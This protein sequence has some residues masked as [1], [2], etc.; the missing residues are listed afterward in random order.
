MSQANVLMQLWP[1]VRVQRVRP[2]TYRVLLRP[3]DYGSE[4]C[5]LLN[6]SS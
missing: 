1:P 4:V 5:A 2:V 3:K 6:Y